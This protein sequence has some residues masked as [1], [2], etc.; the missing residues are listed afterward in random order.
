M[1][2]LNV[3]E[4]AMTEAS[5]TEIPPA[6]KEIEATLAV[7]KALKSLDGDAQE[8]VVE[9]VA[10][11]LGING[12][13]KSANPKETSEETNADTPDEDDP[14]ADQASGTP[15]FA[16]FA[17]LFHAADPQTEAD[18]ALVAGY[19]LQ[20]Y[21]NAD[22]F[23]SQSANRELNHLGHRVGNITQAI[24]ALN[25]QRPALAIQL[26]KSG[27]TRQARKTYKITTSGVAAVK[28]M[29]NG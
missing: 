28:A 5:V 10:G 3:L 15:T 6:E 12:S 26:A 4:I 16:T 23:D 18:K 19:W 8:R 21:K 17:E 24:S 14:V 25:S 29:L 11:I 9:H 7:Y 22:S 20:V 2:W 1:S 27:S 13:L